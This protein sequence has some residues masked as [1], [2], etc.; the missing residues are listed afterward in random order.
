MK[1]ITVSMRGGKWFI[2]IQTE[3]EV[4]DPVYPASRI[5]G[6]ARGVVN[7]AALST[8]EIIAPID[9]FKKHARRLARYQRVM[10]RKQKFS[11]ERDEGESPRPEAPH[12]DRQHPA[13][14][15]APTPHD[16]Q[17]KP[18]GHRDRGFAG[19]EYVQVGVGAG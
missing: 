13:R 1:N 16:A 5:V 11:K 19:T 18:R 2:S 15:S 8:G 6:V 9:A 10:S 14:P 17:P 3:R 7:C 4:A 12:P